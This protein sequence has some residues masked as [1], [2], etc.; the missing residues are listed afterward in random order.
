M[1][2]TRIMYVSPNS[3]LGGGEINQ[4]LLASNVDRSAFDVEVAV[5]DDGPY[6]EELR[7]RG[8]AA[9]V[10]PMPPLRLRSRSAPS[11]LSVF[12]LYRHI[13][14]VRPDIVH[15]SSLP[16]DHHSAIAGRAANVPVIHD[17]QTI[18]YRAMPLERW[19]A[20]SSA[21]VI[22]I[23]HA[24]RKAMA[25]A[26]LPT[27][28]TEVIYSGVDPGIRGKADG[29]R[30]R[31]KFDLVGRDVIGIASRLSPE[32]GHENFLRAAAALKDRFPNARF[33]VAGGAIYAPRE[34]EARLK[35]LAINLGLVGRVV[36]TGFRKDALDL[37]DA[38]DVMVC[39]ADEEA[40][41]RVVLEAMALA[42]PVIATKAG[43]PCETVEDGVTGLLVPPGN[44]SA[45][46]EAIAKLLS[47]MDGARRMGK[48]GQQR[49]A[50]LYTLR[51]NVEK[52]QDLY[53]RV[54]SQRAQEGRK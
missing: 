36:F 44:F 28:N 17:A 9:T 42:K 6:A 41:G 13:G 14:R 16:A 7:R 29:P 4:M 23:S 19:R 20:A 35:Q 24:I 51:Q 34:Y 15:S 32:K 8:I 46:A 45:L 31:R 12:R 11:P 21:R 30:A 38:T 22:C 40:L 39:A 18:I 52:V 43:G 54:L 10:V 25:R 49:A 50:R 2:K 3:L 1:A 26:G 27:H 5:C 48:L 37:I 47:D 33:L 53:R